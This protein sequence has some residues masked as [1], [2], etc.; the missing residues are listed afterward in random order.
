MAKPEQIN[1]M[2]ATPQEVLAQMSKYW[3]EAYKNGLDMLLAI[4]NSALAGA[5]HLRMLQ[6]STDVATQ[7]QNKDALAAVAGARDMQSMMKAQQQLSQAY[8]DSFMKYWSTTAEM[9]QQ[10]QAEMA[11]VMS[12]HMGSFGKGFESMMPPGMMPPGMMPPGMKPGEMPTF[13]TAI[14]AMK[15]SQE[16]MMKAMAGFG[17]MAAGG[18][19]KPEK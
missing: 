12:A 18:A 17:A 1:P 6:L 7:H 4:S 10:S 13:N 8:I 16:V 14:E 11:K 9:V 19:K 3:F 5:E 15:K 2:A